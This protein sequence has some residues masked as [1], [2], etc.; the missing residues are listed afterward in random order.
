MRF[1]FVSKTGSCCGGSR[2]T[3]LTSASYFICAG[4]AVN[5]VVRAFDS[6]H[7]NYHVLPR[8]I[9]VNTAEY[10]VLTAELSPTEFSL[11]NG[12]VHLRK[13]PLTIQES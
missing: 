2:E 10:Q 13:I 11:V 7:T 8:E 1:K 4:D 3:I 12:R 6:F 5:S 9:I